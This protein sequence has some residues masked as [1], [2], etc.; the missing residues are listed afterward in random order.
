MHK[1]FPLSGKSSHWQ[2]KFPLPVEGVPTARRMEIPLPGVCT[3]MMK[4]LDNALVELRKKFEKAKK[5][6]DELK[7]TLEKFQT[8]IKNLSKLLESQISDK[9]GLGYDNQLFKSQVFNC[10]ELNSSDSDDSMPT[11][12]VHDRYKSGEGYHVVHPP[13]TRTFMPPKLD[14]VFSDA[15]PAS[16]TV[17]NVVHVNSSTN[18]TRKEMSKTLRPDAL[19]IEDWTSDFEY[20]YKPESVSNQKE[21]SFIQTT[22]QVKTPRASNS[23]RMTHPHSN[24]HVV[25]IAVLT[26]SRLVPLNTARPVTTAVPQPTVKSQRPGHTQKE[27]IDYEEVVAPVERIEAIR[28]FLAYASFVGFMVYQLD[29]K[30]S[31][32]YGTI[33]EELYVCQ[34]LGFE[35][36]NYPDKNE[37][38]VYVSPSS[39]DKPKKHD[40]KAKRE[41]KEKSPVD[42][43]T[44][45][46]DLKDEFKELFINNTNRVNAANAPVTAV[47]PN[48][49]NSTNTFN[50]ASPSD[51][52]VSSNFEIG[53]KSSFMDP[54][55]YPDYP[56]MPALEDIVY[57]DD[58][59]DVGTEADFSNLKTNISVSPIPTTRV[60]NNHHVTQI[61]G[62]LTPAPQTRSMARMVKEQ[63][64]EDPNYPDKVYKVVK[65]LYG[66]H[67]ALRVCQDKYVA[68]ILRKFSLID[69]KSASTPIDTKKPLLKDPDDI[70]FAICDCARFQV[71][72]KVSHL[73]AVKRIFSNYVG[74]SLDMKSTTRGCQFLGC[75]L[76]SCNEALAI[77]EQTA[78]ELP[79]IGYEKPPPKL[80]FYKAFFSAQWKFLI[81]TLVQCMSAKMTAWHE[82][83]YSMALVVI[84]LATGRKFNFSKYIF[85]NMVRNVDSPSKLLM[86][87]R[88]LQ[89]L[90]NNQL[91]DL[92]SYTTKYTSRALTQKVFANMRRIGKGFSKVETPLLVTMLVQ[93]QAA[94]KEKDEEDEVHAAPT[95]PSLTHEPSPLPHEPITTPLQAQPV[96][97]SSP[98]HDQPTDTSMTLLHTLMETCATLTRQN[99]SSIKDY[100][101]QVDGKEIREE[102]KIKEFWFK[103]VKDSWGRI[104]AID[105]D[106]DIT[107]VYME[108]KVVL[109]AEL[110][111]RI[112]RKYDDNA[113]AKE[114]NAVEPTVFDDE[115][116]TMTMAQ[117][118]IK[119]KAKKARLLD[120]QMAKRLHDEEVEQ[121]AARE[122]QEKDDFEKAKVLQQQYADKQ[123]NIDWNVFVE[124]MQEKHLDNIRKYQS[125][126]RKPISVAQARRNMI[127]YL[128][129]MANT[130]EVDGKE[131]REEEKIKEFWFKEVKDSWGRIEAIDA[132]E[133]ITLVYMET[134]VVLDAELQGRI[135]RKYDDN[136]AAKEVNAVEPTVF[137]DEEVTMTMAQ[138][139]IKIKAKKARLLDEQMAKRLHDEE[140]EQAAAREKQEKDDFEK[141]KVL[142]QQYADKQENIDWN[143]FV[144]QMQEKHLDNIRKY[145]SLKRKP[146]SVAQARRNMIVYLK[147][148]ANTLEDVAEPTK[149]RVAKETLL[150]KSFKK[151]RAK[152]EFSGSKSTQETLTINPKEMSKEDVKNMLE[153]IPVS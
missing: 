76:I 152:V 149:K 84:C 150:Q 131:I 69:G 65:A 74:A 21:P 129:N 3:A 41:A 52:V 111:G 94:A 143:V 9:T 13:Y 72:P 32:L 8:S 81:H 103:E 108:T 148:M 112:E 133:D 40:E 20:E 73:H 142:Q 104:E 14:L 16:T 93:P 43:S 123:E 136:A 120:E 68:E 53:G 11:S 116:V 100:Q 101:A 46:R 92:S 45:V 82:F 33:E 90:I 89:V 121:A 42:L 138:T 1:A 98:L 35:D 132:D 61:I 50:V 22:E 6:K 106:E 57:L 91:D 125:L 95:P 54:S 36:P 115:E 34:P 75:R 153:I 126:K 118:L 145:Q 134:K 7:L 64:F 124:Q 31:F 55:L 44:G 117:T 135:E 59:E 38:E 51:N 18:K 146:I 141:A 127:V 25:P 71:T 78:A 110:Q 140:V 58:E 77:L 19:I 80:T 67:Q 60:H 62:E 37:N 27:G 102:E 105:A 12:P 137:D 79:R 48:P 49:T 47:G 10:D 4:K 30:S 87:P 128:K 39:S 26:R 86:Y 119:I 97:P 88:F 139:L 122:K 29:V 130:L 63:G 107:L 17:L 96:P 114:V 2:Y 70:M 113:A 85:D 147:N 5:E 15:P 151:L 24:G 83:S 28:L 99:C 56:D 144:E 109:D 66:L 23:I